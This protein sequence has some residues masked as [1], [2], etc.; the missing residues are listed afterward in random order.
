MFFSGHFPNVINKELYEV[1]VQPEEIKNC[2]GNT[3][4]DLILVI[5]CQRSTFD[6]H[7]IN[8]E[9]ILSTEEQHLSLSAI[10]LVHK[11]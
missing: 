2:I 10:E 7:A 9:H 5:S 6:N 4:H 11:G 8:K 3:C 1:L